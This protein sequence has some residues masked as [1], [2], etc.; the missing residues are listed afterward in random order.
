ML[1]LFKKVDE[2]KNLKELLVQFKKIKAD[3]KKTSREVRE[4]K[5]DVQLAVQKVGITRFTPFKEIDG[6]QSFSIALLDKKD[7]G[8]IITNIYSKERS[9]TFAKPIENGKSTHTLSK[10]EE[11][12][13]LKAKTIKTINDD[14][15]K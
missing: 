10:E 6:G 8:V 11:E 4:L 7:N 5:K 9:R 1:N 14:K 13:V 12:T 2:P 3:L 15:E